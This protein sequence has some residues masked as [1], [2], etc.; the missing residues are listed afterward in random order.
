MIHEFLYTSGHSLHV[1][2]NQF[3]KICIAMCA[4]HDELTP[5]CLT[6]WVSVWL[7]Y[8]YAQGSISEASNLVV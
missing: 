3:V 1:V 6:S 7:Y 5:N 4:V 8:I 2:Y